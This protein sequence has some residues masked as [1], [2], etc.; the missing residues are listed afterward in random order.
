MSVKHQP[1][2]TDYH[3]RPWLFFFN[4]FVQKVSNN[5]TSTNIVS[6]PLGLHSHTLWMVKQAM[7]VSVRVPTKLLYSPFLYSFALFCHIATL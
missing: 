5:V 2:I 6:T 4:L 3:S 7:S 1:E